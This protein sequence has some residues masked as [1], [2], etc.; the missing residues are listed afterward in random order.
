MNYLKKISIYGIIY[1][2]LI[3][4]FIG[5]LTLSAALP[6]NRSFQKNLRYSAK[7]LYEEGDWPYV[8]EVKLDNFADALILN[9]EN[10]TERV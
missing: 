3:T 8:G 6:K 2:S 10:I 7:Y 4:F 9:S 1:L 5:L